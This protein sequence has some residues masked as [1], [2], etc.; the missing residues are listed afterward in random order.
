MLFII[1]SLI[2]IGLALVIV[3]IIFIPGTTVV[4]VLGVV[5]T[6]VGVGLGYREYGSSTGHLILASASAAL[7]LMI[8]YSFRSNTWS[9]FALKNT[10]DSKN[11]EGLLQ[12]FRAG[13]EGICVSALRPVGKAEFGG[14]LVE[15]AS[16]GDYVDA[17]T[18]VRIKE[19]SAAGIIVEQ[20]R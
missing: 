20:I 5:V 1:S 14:R 13:E 9:R 7:G 10:I 11:N 2:I 8:Y 12:S 3:E 6:I 4:G 15:V 16:E 18:R 17:G 19:V